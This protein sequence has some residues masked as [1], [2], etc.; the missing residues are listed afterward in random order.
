MGDPPV[1]PIAIYKNCV[2]G[3]IVKNASR[4]IFTPKESTEQA[5]RFYQKI[6]ELS[7]NK[8]IRA[9]QEKYFL[10]LVSRAFKCYER[11]LMKWLSSF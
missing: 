10:G 4:P 3:F 11:R 6:T 2:L 9:N 8:G 7:K 5:F 1:L